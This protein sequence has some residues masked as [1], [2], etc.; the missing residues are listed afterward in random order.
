M[1]LLPNYAKSKSPILKFQSGRGIWI[2]ILW[3]LILLGLH[4]QL[5]LWGLVPHIWT[6]GFPLK[7]FPLP[8]VFQFWKLPEKQAVRTKWDTITTLNRQGENTLNLESIRPPQH[9]FWDFLMTG[10]C[11]STVA[12]SVFFCPD[13][14]NEKKNSQFTWDSHQPHLSP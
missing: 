1:C 10:L 12:G 6:L 13:N 8:K 14:E 2:F 4:F 9:I 5:N 3:R 7:Q 11:E